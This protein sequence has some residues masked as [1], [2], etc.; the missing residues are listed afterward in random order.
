MTDFWYRV[1]ETT[2]SAGV[3]DLGDP[4]PGGPTRTNLQVHRVLRHTPCGVVIDDGLFGRFI[5]RS[6]GK[7]YA[8]PTVEEAIESFKQRKRAQ[9]RICRARIRQAEE[10][11]VYLDNKGFYGDARQW[12]P[13]FKQE[14]AA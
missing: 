6:W 10:A 3:D 9:I 1:E 13:E 12:T 4:I 14:T 7:R 2:Y 11:M 8:C 5:N